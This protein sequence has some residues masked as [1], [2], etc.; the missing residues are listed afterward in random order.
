MAAPR[1]GDLRGL[2]SPII[3]FST[4]PKQPQNFEWCGHSS[5]TDSRQA[6]LPPLPA[7]GRSPPL[8]TCYIYTCW[9]RH[10]DNETILP[11]DLTTLVFPKSSHCS[12][13]QF[14][15]CSIWFTSLHCSIFH[16]YPFL[17]FSFITTLSFPILFS[18]PL[19]TLHCLS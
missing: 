10:W 15:L 16:R 7:S 9:Y 19:L 12:S 8:S 6:P 4:H 13:S 5:S 2:Q 3:P 11:T 1:R 17:L 14:H 18:L